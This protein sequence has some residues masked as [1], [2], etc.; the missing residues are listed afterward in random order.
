MTVPLSYR[1]NQIVLPGDEPVR[2]P[3]LEDRLRQKMESAA[4]K[5][6]LLSGDVAL[7]LNEVAAIAD[8]LKAAG[9]EHVGAEISVGAPPGR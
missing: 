8:I 7:T 2:I 9:V 3:D 5:E 4:R 1:E 6:V